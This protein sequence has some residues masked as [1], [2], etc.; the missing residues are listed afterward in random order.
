MNK[1]FINIKIDREERPDLDH[2]YMDA[3]QAMTGSGGWPL[4]VFLTPECKPFYGG[5]YFPPQKAFNR[6]SWQDVLL[7]VSQAFLERRN[8]INS[9]AENLTE[10]LIQSNSFG[11]SLANDENF[12]S[13]EKTDEIFRNLMKS[14]DRTWG[15]FSRAPKFPQSF[16]IQYLLR[17]F[18]ISGNQ[19]GLQHALLSIDKMIDGGIY[20]HVGGGFSRYS[21]DT[22]WLVPHF[23]KMLYDNALLISVLSE[24][25]QLT[26]EPRYKEVIDETIQFLT[27]EM[28]HEEGGF[29]S[30]LDADSEGEEGKFYIWDFAEVN[31]VLKTDAEIFCN[32]FD[33]SNKGN[34]EGKNILRRKKKAEDYCSEKKLSI[35]EFHEIINRGKKL[36]LD[37]RFNRI[38]PQTD[39]KVLLGWNALTNLALSKAYAASSNDNYRQL[40]EKN[41]RFLI[42]KFAD[43]D[44]GS[45]FHSWKNSQA[46]YPAFLDD[47]A[48]LIQ[49]LIHLQ[50]ITGKTDYL[51]QAKQI[52]KFVIQNF[53]D[54]ESDLF[55][56]TNK[57]QGDVLVRKKEIYDGA[58]PSGN[59][60]MTEN[61]FKLSLYFDIPAWRERSLNMIR[62]PGNVITKYPTSFAAWACLLQ[63]LVNG[64]NEIA[65]VGPWAKNVLKNVLEKYIPHKILMSTDNQVKGFPLL[66]GKN[67]TEKIALYLCRNYACEKPVTSVEELLALIGSK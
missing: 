20:D 55:F 66:S 54:P 13:K 5:T 65:I 26:G 1:N 52:T 64:T 62:I 38:R 51:D 4:N 21:T 33:I 45:F 15:G 49:A 37:K 43:G 3:V 40:A 11:N 19:E 6:P 46:K 63:E 42:S 60:I 24:A 58:Q 22:E 47:Y 41:M 29:Y 35:E 57:N 16:V 39:D 12:V 44:A 8:E 17:Y 59:A 36:L 53:S 18:H 23:E 32:F 10:H 27:R 28:M 25:F 9:Q 2:V 30:A 34:W 14:A 61:L 7:G 56:Y 50:E 48:F 31:H 67:P